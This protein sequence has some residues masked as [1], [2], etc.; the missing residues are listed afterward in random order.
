LVDP[1]GRY[2]QLDPNSRCAEVFAKAFKPGSCA[3]EYAKEFNQKASKV[4]ILSVSSD[5]SPTA[6]LTEDQVSGNGS[7]QTLGS[8]FFGAVYTPTA[9]TLAG[10]K[11]VIVLGP[12]F[13][14]TPPDVQDA[15]L[16]HKEV[17]AVTGYGD[18][19]IFDMLRKYGL[20]STDFILDPAHPTG[21]FTEWIR[22]GCPPKKK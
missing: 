20:P 10:G 21:E 2:A 19:V 18:E 15:T 12:G 6:K 5:K 4:P 11:P 22:K 9:V 1:T 14:N 7:L 13:G 8:Y 16:V 17:H 3:E